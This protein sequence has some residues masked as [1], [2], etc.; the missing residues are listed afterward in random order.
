MILA[1]AA[2]ITIGFFFVLRPNLSSLTPEMN[3]LIIFS[4]SLI[5]D[6]YL[7]QLDAHKV[8]TSHLTTMKMSARQPKR[9]VEMTRGLEPYTQTMKKANCYPAATR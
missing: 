1:F 2:M 9:S 4:S 7:S 6:F 8:I 3:K 5:L